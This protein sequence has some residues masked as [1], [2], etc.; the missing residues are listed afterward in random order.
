M[1]KPRY[2]MSVF[3]LAMTCAA[4]AAAAQSDNYPVKP[5]HWIVPFPPGGSVDLKN[6]VSKW[7]KVIKERGMRAD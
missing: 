5:I 3:V 1:F 6:E 4:P 7:G 2:F